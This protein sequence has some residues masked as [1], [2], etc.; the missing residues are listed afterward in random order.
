MKHMKR[1]LILTLISGLSFGFVLGVWYERAKPPLVCMEDMPC[2]DCKTMGNEI[3]GPDYEPD[4][5]M[6]NLDEGVSGE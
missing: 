1:A 4:S 3:C 5:E 2:W 6:L